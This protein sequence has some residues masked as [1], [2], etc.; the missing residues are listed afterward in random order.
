VIERQMKPG[1]V[2][3]RLLTPLDIPTAME[4]SSDAGWNQTEA[5]WQML[6]DLEPEG[7][8]GIEC[9]GRIVATTTLICYGRELAWI[10]M[11][12]T[13][14]DYRHRGFATRLVETALELARVRRIATVKLDATESGQPL[15]ANFGFVEEQHV[16]RWSGKAQFSGSMPPTAGSL[17]AEHMNSLDCEAYGADRALVLR[18][19]GARSMPAA[20]DDGY[21]LNRN[22]QRAYYLGPCIARSQS[23]ARASIANLLEP[24]EGSVC[25]WDLLPNNRRA[26][27]LAT[28]LGFTRVRRLVRMRYGKPLPSK[29]ELIYAIAGFELG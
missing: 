7:C 26:I 20:A 23:A 27:S 8:F 17:P 29:D 3:V 9:D 4:L 22:G 10:G 11:V 2:E 5:D 24:S 18:Y 1:A 25:F 16:E 6:L 21:L 19:L 12:L 15:Y 28:E 13:H 14:Q